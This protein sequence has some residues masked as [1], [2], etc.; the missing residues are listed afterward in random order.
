VVPNEK[1]LTETAALPLAVGVHE[2]H[3]ERPPTLPA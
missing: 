3:T 2:Y 1:L